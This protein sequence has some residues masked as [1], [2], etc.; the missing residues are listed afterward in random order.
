MNNQ[1]FDDE[2]VAKMNWWAVA[3]LCCAV[4]W[5]CAVGLAV[6]MVK[7]IKPTG[8]WADWFAV[9]LWFLVLF[10]MITPVVGLALSRVARRRA[11]QCVHL[12]GSILAPIGFGL[13]LLQLGLTLVV[14]PAVL[15]AM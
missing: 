3:V 14:V 9:Q 1:Q 2:G 7:V 4:S 12:R 8:I 5:F 13:S 15:I 6:L 11:E 10:L